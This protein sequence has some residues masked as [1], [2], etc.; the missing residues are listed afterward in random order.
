MLP[1]TVELWAVDLLSDV[2]EKRYLQ[3]LGPVSETVKGA[4]EHS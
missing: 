2:V 1:T 3:F 4:T